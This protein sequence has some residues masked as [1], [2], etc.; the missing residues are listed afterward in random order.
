MYSS[1]VASVLE[2]AASSVKLEEVWSLKMEAASKYECVIHHSAVTVELGGSQ[3]VSRSMVCNGVPLYEV[4][5]WS[6]ITGWPQIGYEVCEISGSHSHLVK[7]RLCWLV[8]GEWW[9]EGT[10]LL[11][12]VGNY[13]LTHIPEYLV[14]SSG[15]ETSSRDCTF[16]CWWCYW[17]IYI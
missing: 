6:H 11:Q 15:Y 7:H 17:C 5:I 3:M 13:Q 8:K 14:V 1:M 2:D 4:S 16:F 9:C 10:A 12:N